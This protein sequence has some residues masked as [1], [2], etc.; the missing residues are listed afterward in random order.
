MHMIMK[1]LILIFQI[2]CLIG[3]TSGIYIEITMHADIGFILI[4]LGSVMF[5]ASEKVRSYY[6]HRKHNEYL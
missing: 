1:V 6:L 2:L 4:T 5:G 3:L